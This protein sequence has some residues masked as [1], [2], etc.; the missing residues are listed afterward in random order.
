MSLEKWSAIASVGLFAMFVG[1]MI[2]IYYFMMDTPSNL[3]FAVAFEPAPKILQFISIGVAPASILAALSFILSKRYGSKPIG[4]MIIAGGLILLIG[5]AY[6]YTLLDK[7][8][9]TY[10]V[11]TVI[12]TP[13]LF[14][15][16]SIP[17]MVFG[18]ILFR[19]NKKRPKK[20]Y[21]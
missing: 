15:G 19:I 1:E 21:F 2:S 5:M 4:S 3:E 6:C 17:V 10:I 9:P 16:V 14:M 13:L 20:E 11:D 12:I 8:T 18:V 7:L